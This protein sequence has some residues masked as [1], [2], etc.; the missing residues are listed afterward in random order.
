MKKL[1]FLLI[2]VAIAYNSYSIDPIPAFVHLKFNTTITAEK[3]INENVFAVSFI[4]FMDK[5]LY[6]SLDGR[7]NDECD[8][9]NNDGSINTNFDCNL[10]TK[11]ISL[12]SF[13]LTSLKIKSDPDLVFPSGSY[14]SATMGY[15]VT[16]F[17]SAKTL[18]YCNNISPNNFKN[19]NYTMTKTPE[20]NNFKN[21]LNSDVLIEKCHKANRRF[22]D[23][24][25]VTKLEIT[26][27]TPDLLADIER[28]DLN[29]ELKADTETTVEIN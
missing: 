9:L 26:G 18:V 25:F 15:K 12:S 28:V 17:D 13:T 27:V 19:G 4:F 29:F 16:S 2:I 11:D 8:S 1:S 7:P 14:I 10:C 3:T 6:E 5:Q 22:N 23:I 24:F 20:F 21:E